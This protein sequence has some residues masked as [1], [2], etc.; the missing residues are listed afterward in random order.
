MDYCP[1][2]LKKN[3]RGMSLTEILIVVSLLSILAVVLLSAFKPGTQLAKARDARRKADLQKLKNPLEDYY[4]DN[5]CYPDPPLLDCKLPADN[6]GTNFQ[7][8][9]D[10]V[11]CDPETNNKYYYEKVNCNTYRIYVNLE[12]KSD[13]AI[14]E[15]GCTNGCGPSPYYNWGISSPNTNLVPVGPVE[16][17]GTWVM[18]SGTTCHVAPDGWT[19]EKWCNSCPPSSDCPS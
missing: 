4:N 9:K 15:T 5:K 16:C 12:Y 10:K 1:S 13:P 3:L 2:I 6:P 19:G 11:P 14:A 17:V 18:C 8:Y 7:P